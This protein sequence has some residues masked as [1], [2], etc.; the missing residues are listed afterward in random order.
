MQTR[1]NL[2]NCLAK[3]LYDNVAE[4]PDELAFR[5]G[6]IL[7]VLEQNTNSL[8]GWWLCSLRGR[9][10][11]VPGNRLRLL[12]GMYDPTGLGTVGSSTADTSHA[13]RRNWGLNPNK[14]VTPQKI[15]DVYLYDIPVAAKKDERL[16]SS[17]SPYHFQGYN[18]VVDS[19]GGSYDTP[20]SPRSVCQDVYDEPKAHPV[21][22][23]TQL[24][25]LVYDMPKHH[26][27]IPISDAR[28]GS[29]YDI[30]TVDQTSTYD[31]PRPSEKDTSH[32]VSHIITISD[33]YDTPPAHKSS[34]PIY[35]GRAFSRSSGDT[36][37]SSSFRSLSGSHSSMETLSLSSVSGSNRSS[38]EQHP[39]DLYDIPPEPQPVSEAKMSHPARSVYTA[40]PCQSTDPQETYDTPTNNMPT[41]LYDT[42]V[43]RPVC[44]PGM[45]AVYNI[46]PQALKDGM[47]PR[48]IAEVCA[49]VNMPVEAPEN[50][51]KVLLSECAEL[52]LPLNAAIEMLVNC[53]CD[54]QGA[55]SKLFS[56]VSTTW[57]EEEN[58]ENNICD[59]KITC[60]RIQNSLDGF[61]SFAK[62]AL[63]NSIHAA[64][65]TLS[66]KL[67]KLM[68]PLRDS[69]NLL[70]N[71]VNSIDKKG[72]DAKRLS[73]KEVEAV[74]NELD[75]LVTCARNLV[76]EVRQVAS[77][78]QGNSTLLFSQDSQ[79][80]NVIGKPPVAPKPGLIYGNKSSPKLQERPLPPT[81]AGLIKSKL[82]SKEY[83]NEYDYV[84]VES[85]QQVSE[86]ENGVTAPTK[87]MCQQFE[88]KDTGYEEQNV[89]PA[90]DTS[91]V[92]APLNQ[93]DYQLL[94]FYG[95]QVNSHINHLTNAID[96]FLNTIKHN[97][98][99]KVFVGHSKFIVISAHK[100]VY[101]GDTVHRNIC[102][103]E[104]KNRIMQNSNNL[105][106]TLK[107]LVANT[108]KAAA[109]FPS[110]AA[111]QTMVDSV[112]DV[113]H[114][115]KD[116]KLSILQAAKA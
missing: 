61:Y 55:I 92:S 76:E 53:Q 73:S 81:P 115:A 63:A 24:P 21:T 70:K 98:P 36:S 49:S 68:R 111:V 100:L 95:A 102:N 28:G 52:P 67:T 32:L 106:D 56:F 59:I 13:M 6:D 60:H 9:Q 86:S 5:K 107:T 50:R 58:M 12:P 54:V 23:S 33:A 46:P 11:I 85:E 97:Q 75:Q 15:G 96:A 114:L 108:K 71:C 8:E 4:A 31:V 116:L 37:T 14:V 84:N 69:Y 112:V 18:P 82:A 16:P 57:R 30:P 90:V 110:V 83:F 80:S 39:N 38:L 27:P 26:S 45:E 22:G 72:W 65:K 89:S 48:S 10:G 88:V 34:P 40:V 51:D 25:S 42:P 41:Q 3:A 87:E 93:K 104:L 109:E 79:S 113:S 103:V 1:L 19:Q 74:P 99:P 44:S 17:S 101:I 7:T 62:G 47:S 43:S 2:S 20:P 94:H 29:D 105:C 66:L 64:D 35:D 77:F 78:I 91:E